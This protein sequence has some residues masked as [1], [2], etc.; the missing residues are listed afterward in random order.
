MWDWESICL[1]RELFIIAYSYK[2]HCTQTF[3]LQDRY[4]DPH[5]PNPSPVVHVRG[6]SDAAIEADLVEAVQHFGAVRDVIMMPRRKQ[7]LIEFEV[8]TGYFAALNIHLQCLYV[9]LWTSLLK[10]GVLH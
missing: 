8:F 7:A 3:D 1:V 2:P 5:K 10:P 9:W 4:E 6:L